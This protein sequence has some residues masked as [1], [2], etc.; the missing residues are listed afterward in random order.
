MRYSHLALSL[1]LCVLI[2]PNGLVNAANEPADRCTAAIQRAAGS[3]SRCLLRADA[4]LALSNDLDRH[5]KKVAQCKKAYARKH[6]QAVHRYGANNCPADTVGDFQKNIFR[7]T[8]KITAAAKDTVGGTTVPRLGPMT[9][10]VKG[11]NYQPTPSDYAINPLT[12]APP[13]IYFDTDFYNQDF[14]QLWGTGTPPDQ[15]GG[16]ND[17][18]DMLSLGVNFVRVFNWDAGGIVDQ[19]FRN[20]NPWL[21]SLADAMIYTAGVFSNGNRATP[22][23][24]MV[25][26][27]FNSFSAEVKDII[28]VWL[29]GNEISPA[30]PFTLE[31]LQVI[32]DSAQPPL[33]TIPICVPF[34]MSSTQDTI[35]KVKTNYEQQFTPKGLENRFIACLNFYGLGQSADTQPPAQQLEDFITG[36][37]ADSFIRDHKIALLLTEFGINYSPPLEPNAGSND[38]KQGT[39]LDDMLATSIAL[40]ARH[41]R[42]LGQAVFE[43]A[44]ESWKNP[45]L[46]EANFGLYSLT[47]QAPPLTGKT[48]RPSDPPYPVDTRV[49][50]PQHKAVADNY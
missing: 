6:S 35:N 39:F 3:H 49:A 44:N 20:H 43:Y 14:I 19:P 23:A 36:F 45:P 17:M 46:A 8:A 48:T 10:A 13:S 1:T 24:Q 30:D 31:T 41:S 29:I 21:E 32:K 22:Q 26:N 25:V 50:R 34:Q 7:L 27:Q 2:L 40:Q 18:G 11:I 15:P 5:N 38:A 47:T 28:A 9:E 33:D 16:R 12:K 37:F 4:R 42:Y